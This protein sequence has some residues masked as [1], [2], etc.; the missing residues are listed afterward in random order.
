LN[1]KAFPRLLS[2][3]NTSL[4]FLES[5]VTYNGL[6]ELMSWTAPH[7]THLNFF[8]AEVIWRFPQLEHLTILYSL[9]KSGED[10]VS[11]DFNL[12][13]KTQKHPREHIRWKPGSLAAKQAGQKNGPWIPGFG[14]LAAEKTPGDLGSNPSRATSSLFLSRSFSRRGFCVE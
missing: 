1:P 4:A 11:L 7:L 2:S 10:G 12:K 5:S 8:L 6:V 3:A 9:P 14:S 13:R